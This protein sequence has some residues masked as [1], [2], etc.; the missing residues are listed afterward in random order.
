MSMI[1]YRFLLADEHDERLIKNLVA[2]V[3]AFEGEEA[4]SLHVLARDVEAAHRRIFDVILD[5]GLD[6]E[7]IPDIV[8]EDLNL[9]PSMLRQADFFV[10]MPE[11]VLDARE[12][13]LPACVEA[14]AELFQLAQAHFKRLDWGLGSLSLQ[15]EAKEHWLL[16]EPQAWED[17]LRVFLERV[18]SSSDVALLIRVSAEESHALHDSIAEWLQRRG[19]DLDQIPD[20]LLID[21]PAA[22]GAALFRHASAWI[23]TG[24]PL[25]RAIA[26]VLG[27]RT[28]LLHAPAVITQKHY[29]VSAVV[30]TYNA[31][32]FI[33]G[34]LADLEAESI[35]E[36]MEILV[37]DSGSEQREGE[38][39]R[40][41]QRRYDNIRYLR[42][43]RESVY[44]AWN[45]GIRM[46]RGT[47]ITNAN[48]DDRRRRECTETLVRALEAQPDKVLAYGDSIVTRTPNQTFETCSHDDYLNW[49]DFDRL[50]LLQYCYCGPHPVWKRSL[51]EDL[52]YFDETYRCAADYEFWLRAA[53]KYEFIHVPRL[54]GAYWLDDST[55]SRRGDLPIIEAN[56]I[57]RDYQVKY[58]AAGL[59]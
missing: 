4:V 43:E 46:A 49:P 26:K 52:G 13:G 2:Y 9:L 6:P 50:T 35:A 7:G 38:I 5:R 23:D 53:Q 58:L 3:S 36:D 33:R 14:S 57:K 27:V 10:G 8:V 37:I 47:Y 59:V 55:V 54:L 12:L 39:V 40:E 30:S 51:H 15:T 42:T 18:G 32:G 31:E 20:I 21:D 29:L 44:Q 25:E 17:A 56:A 24:E 19:Y 28:L 1:P 34:C 16:T 11:R 22:Q 48:T 45:R 41:F